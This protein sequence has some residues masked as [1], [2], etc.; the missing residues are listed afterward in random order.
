[1]FMAN[2]I[3][4]PLVVIVFIPTTFASLFTN[5]PPEFPGLMAESV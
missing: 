1:M 3:P 4:S 2:P 5:G